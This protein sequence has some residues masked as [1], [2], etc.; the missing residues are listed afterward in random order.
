MNSGDGGH[1]VVHA[2]SNT[3]G[4]TRP[5]PSDRATKL[6]S[7]EFGGGSV[8]FGYETCQFRGV[9]NGPRELGESRGD[10]GWL[11]GKNVA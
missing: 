2:D 4:M 6:A 7:D 10:S 5:R 8:F 11:L 3:A 9:A 1:P